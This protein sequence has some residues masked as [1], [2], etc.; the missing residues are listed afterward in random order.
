[1]LKENWK[2]SVVIEADAFKMHDPI[3]EQLN[4]DED[5]ANEVGMVVHG[6][7]TDAANEE[8][9]A[10]LNQVGSRSIRFTL[11][12]VP[13]VVSLFDGIEDAGDAEASEGCH[14]PNDF[15]RPPAAATNTHC[16]AP[17]DGATYI[18]PGARHTFVTY[19]LVGGYFAKFVWAM[20]TIAA[21][22][23]ATSV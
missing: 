22:G 14:L 6:H 9:I 5:G 8:L 12:D 11:A 3:F 21:G 16:T 20:L 17:I 13:A 7:S 4:K 2:D 1:M 10:E 18:N 23:A 15:S 19:R